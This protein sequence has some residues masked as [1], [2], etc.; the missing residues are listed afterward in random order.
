MEGERIRL[1]SDKIVAHPKTQMSVED[2]QMSMI[3]AASSRMSAS[4]PYF[5]QLYVTICR[6]TQNIERKNSPELSTPLKSYLS[7]PRF[8]ILG[9]AGW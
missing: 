8:S 7:C 4:L 3:A 9:S 1:G 5:D 2:L 6:F